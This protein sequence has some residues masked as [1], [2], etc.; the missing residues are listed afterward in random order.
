MRVARARSGGR[1]FFG[2]DD[3]GAAGRVAQHAEAVRGAVPGRVVGRAAREQVRRVVAHG[4]LE[5]RRRERVDPPGPGEREPAG[6]HE[7]GRAPQ[8]QRDEPRARAAPADRDGRQERLEE[9]QRAPLAPHRVAQVAQVR[10]AP[11]Q[12]REARLRDRHAGEG[13]G[14]KG[15]ETARAY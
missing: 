1:P 8:V 6:E 10:V 13:A 5:A 15:R 9:L 12:A 11:A 3:D 14:R 7:A 4:V 2:R